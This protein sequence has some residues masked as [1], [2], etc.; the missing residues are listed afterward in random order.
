MLNSW[1]EIEQN[2]RRFF[3]NV[4]LK[5][6][7]RFE[8]DGQHYLFNVATMT[9]H[10]IT[11]SLARQIDRLARSFA[12]G[13]VSEAMMNELR[14]LGL[15]AGD[16]PATPCTP[17]AAP[18]AT[19]QGGTSGKPAVGNIALFVAQQCNMACVYCY[20]QG[21]EY[22]D[23]GMMD[24]NIA[25]K[26]IDW[27]MVNSD[28]ID[29][30][31]VGFFG[32]EPMMNF[33]LITKVVKYAKKS[34]EK[35][36]KTVSFSMTTN[37][38]LLTDR[39][40]DFLRR[41]NIRP[42]VS[43]DGSAELQNRQRPFRNGKAS[44]KKVHANVQKLI[45]VF[46]RTM[47]RAT[48]YGDTDP[49]EIRAGV[50]QAGFRVF[51]IVRASPVILAGTIPV[52]TTQLQVSP[53]D[54]RRLALERTLAD[55]FLC[56]IKTRTFSATGRNGVV[57]FYMSQLLSKSKRHYYCG[58]GRGMAAVTASGEI[59]PCHRFAGQED[60]KLGTLESYRVDG[61][62]DHH[63]AQVDRLPECRNCWARYA[64]GGGCAYQNKA[65]RG[66]WHLPDISSCQETK[67]LFE[68]SIHLYL[69]LDEDDRQYFS[70]SLTEIQIDR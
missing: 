48:H 13:F 19:D 53:A 47:A 70:S 28:R 65:V 10:R 31:H 11:E 2:G 52:D 54:V 51:S 5:E 58:I 7:H 15:V 26:A 67:D 69:Q 22:A 49:A 20:G 57:G 30:V 17:V 23:K 29:K 9:P 66:D 59:Y 6:F 56:T 45:K 1:Y 37:A 46:P 62:T 12:S 41:E 36:G 4:V 55:E 16:E 34:A 24:E 18:A 68:L 61:L 50:E 60:M 43:F 14:R 44:Y 21:G 39:R 8:R 64:C 32:G 63:Q 27:L 3:G 25:F 33:P 35:L 42:L 40:I 38:S